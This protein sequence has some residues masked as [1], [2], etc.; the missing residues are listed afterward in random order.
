MKSWSLESRQ[1]VKLGLLSDQIPG[2]RKR[3]SAEF[4][5]LTQPRDRP[6][7][8]AD[9]RKRRLK[10]MGLGIWTRSI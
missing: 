7:L 3:H 2:K 9:L 4:E 10:P 8:V 6:V 5:G 1:G